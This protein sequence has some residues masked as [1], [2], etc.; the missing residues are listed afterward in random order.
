MQGRRA[1]SSWRFGVRFFVCW[2][3]RRALVKYEDGAETAGF[4]FFGAVGG[5]TNWGMSEWGGWQD[6]NKG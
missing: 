3:R 5:T 1:F 2:R 6:A 4:A